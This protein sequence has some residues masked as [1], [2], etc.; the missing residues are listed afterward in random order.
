MDENVEL[1]SSAYHMRKAD[2]HY[3]MAGLARQDGDKQDAA[4]HTEEAKKHDRLARE[5]REAGR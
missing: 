2:Q 5:S 4:R 3:E 1:K